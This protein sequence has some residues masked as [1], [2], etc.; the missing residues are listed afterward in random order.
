MSDC[1]D[2]LMKIITLSL[3]AASAAATALA[4]PKFYA[5]AG[6]SYF[7]LRSAQFEAAPAPLRVNEGSRAAPFIAA[8]YSFTERFG[9]RLSYH[10]V[11]DITATAAFPRQPGDPEEVELPVVVY[12]QYKDDVHLVGLAP[13]FR[14]SLAPAWQ[15]TISPV[16]NWV[17][18]RGEV[19][20]SSSV[21]TFAAIPDRRVHDDG[22]TFGG[23]IGLEW[24]IAERAALSLSY[25]YT[26]LDPSFDREAHIFSGGVRW[27]F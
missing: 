16:L 21:P 3:L 14:W 10:Y 1:K 20:Y 26:D 2:T 7:A 12:G 25:Q 19:R 5:E 22:F 23:S 27:K 13:E 6:L 4:Q 24:T 9:L 15:L 11:H 8:G 17:E 18:S